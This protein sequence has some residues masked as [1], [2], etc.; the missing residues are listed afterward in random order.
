MKGEF[1]YCRLKRDDVSEFE[2]ETWVK[3]SENATANNAVDVVS[4]L[5]PHSRCFGGLSYSLQ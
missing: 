2:S 5:Q 4:V 1:F 3:I